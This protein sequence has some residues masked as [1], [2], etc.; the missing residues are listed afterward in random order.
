MQQHLATFRAIFYP[1]GLVFGLSLAA[2]GCFTEPKFSDTPQISF[3][4]I[5]RYPLEA[6]TGVGQQKRDSLIITIGFTDGNGDLGNDLPIASDEKERYTQA[7]GW[8]NYR[9]RAFRLE[10]NQYK[11]LA[12]GENT[13]LYFPRLSR[14]GKKGA[15]EGDLELEQVYQYGDTYKI[16]PTKFRIQIRDRA[17]N[18]SN[19]IETDTISVPYSI[20]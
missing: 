11:E 20:R 4:G 9:I 2:S 12:T 13:S 18:I 17:L 5:S 19:E 8:G 7:G 6:G 1:Y 15:I 3:K 16:Y 10:N 14:E